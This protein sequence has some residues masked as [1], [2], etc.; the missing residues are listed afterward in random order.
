VLQS[1]AEPA[2]FAYVLRLARQKKSSPFA[3]NL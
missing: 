2:G 1:L 3:D